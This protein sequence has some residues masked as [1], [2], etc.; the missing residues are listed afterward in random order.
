MVFKY[1]MEQT[2]EKPYDAPIAK[3]IEVKTEGI[4]CAS[5]DQYESIP[6]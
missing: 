1:S 4:I 2:I 3:V 6:W 5:M